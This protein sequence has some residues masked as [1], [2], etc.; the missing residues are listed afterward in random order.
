MDENGQKDVTVDTLLEAL[1]LIGVALVVRDVS[2]HRMSFSI[3]NM[4]FT[5]STYIH[6]TLSVQ[7][8]MAGV[9]SSGEQVRMRNP[10]LR[11]LHSAVRTAV[12]AVSLL[13]AIVSPVSPDDVSV[14]MYVCMY[15]CMQ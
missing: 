2:T 10:V 7:S 15:V 3:V 11:G 13:E 8:V 9:R 1:V 4:W 14:C 6:T 5:Y 12:S